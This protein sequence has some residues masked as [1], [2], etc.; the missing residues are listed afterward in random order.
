MRKL[1]S[2]LLE[3]EK[4]R[5]DTGF[6]TQVVSQD[7]RLVKSDGNFNVKKIGQSFGARANIFHRLITM[8]WWKLA[9]VVFTFYFLT[10]LLFAFIYSLVGIEHLQGIMPGTKVQNFWEAFF[11]SSQT[12]TTLGYG[13][14][15]PVGLGANIVSSI[16]ALVGLLAFSIT[17][18]L[19]YGR[20]SRPVP[21]ILYSDKAIV[22]PYLDIQGLMI[23]MANEKSNQL[24][25]VE[26]TLI[27]SRNELKNG[28]IT[29]QYYPL[30]LERKFV[31][32]FSLSWTIVH[33][34]TESSPLFDQTPETLRAS[35]SELLLSVDGINDTFSDTINSRRSFLFDEI[36]FGQ[37]F[38]NIVST[39]NNQYVLD[40]SKINELQK[41]K[42]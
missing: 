3:L 16:E 28:I 6:G 5:E 32:Y 22:A 31:K 26:A 35:N 34:I 11:F 39:E 1:K 13:R 41:E 2:N 9:F 23:K 40:L 8:P 25:N 42:S 4:K 20:F 24:I 36:I 19:L 14:V 12:L 7:T 29:R 33:P 17:T 30:E 10:N 37:K 27:Y 38:A 18:G 15:A 21:M